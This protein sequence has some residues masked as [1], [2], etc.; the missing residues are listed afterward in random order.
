MIFADI[1]T[2]FVTN[3]SLLVCLSLL[4]FVIIAYVLSCVVLDVL[5]NLT[6]RCSK[7][8]AHDIPHKQM[9]RTFVFAT[10]LCLA[11]CLI[12][13]SAY[14]PGSFGYDVMDQYEQAI[15]GRYND[16]HPVWH[17][18]IFFALPLRLIGGWI[19]SIILFQILC[20]SLT[21]GY[22]CVF[23]Y[24]YMGLK[25][26]AIVWLYIVLNPYIGQ[27]IIAPLKDV[28]FAMAGGISMTLAARIY[29]SENGSDI[30]WYN[31]VILGFMLANAAIFR[32]NGIIFSVFLLIALV[33]NTFRE[34]YKWG[35]S[36]D[37]LFGVNGDDQRLGVFCIGG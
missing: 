28:A 26:T 33:I 17:T 13:F 1:M 5:S 20:F 6:F 23:V 2:V 7:Y 4:S 34:S 36:S 37:S 3:N 12:W 30:K 22:I 16:W 15:M 10:I 32:H 11:V 9:G 35:G 27:I 24:Q 14:Y 18:I 21:I 31:Y 19:G 8:P 25:A 29:L